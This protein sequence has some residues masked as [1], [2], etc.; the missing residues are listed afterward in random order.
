[1]VAPVGRDKNGIWFYLCKHFLPISIPTK[2]A[3]YVLMSSVTGRY[4][5]G[6]R[7]VKNIKELERKKLHLDSNKKVIPLK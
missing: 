4:T 3:G 5:I 7:T 1:M 6:H 2:I